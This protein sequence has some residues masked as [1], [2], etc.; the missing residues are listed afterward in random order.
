MYLEAAHTRAYLNTKLTLETDVAWNTTGRGRSQRELATGTL[1]QSTPLMAAAAAG[2]VHI[3][4]ALLELGANIN[5]ECDEVNARSDAQFQQSRTHITTWADEE[6]GVL[7]ASQRGRGSGGQGGSG[8]RHASR[9]PKKTALSVAAADGRLAVVHFLLEQKADPNSVEKS[10]GSG[11]GNGNRGGSVATGGGGGGSGAGLGGL[12]ASLSSSPSSPPPAATASKS[13]LYNAASRGHEDV[14]VALCHAGANPNIQT[15]SGGS[16]LVAAMHGTYVARAS[17]EAA[18]RP[19]CLGL[20][21]LRAPPHTA[22]PLNPSACC[23]L[24]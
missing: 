2:H 13:P 23:V 15:K 24:S 22:C 21:G 18:H 20:S 9:A 16:P 6:R 4:R 11:N 3:V 17:S 19:A 7:P 8:S 5:T 10:C 1:G 12:L 14:V